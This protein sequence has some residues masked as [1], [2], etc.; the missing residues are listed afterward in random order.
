MSNNVSSVYWMKGSLNL[1]IILK[2]QFGYI[3][4]WY[5]FERLTSNQWKLPLFFCVLTFNNSLEKKICLSREIFFSQKIIY[6]E[7]HHTTW[8]HSNLH[9]FMLSLSLSLTH[10]NTC[11]HAS[12]HTLSYKWIFNIVWAWFIYS[13]IHTPFFA[14]NP[15]ASVW[16]W[17]FILVIFYGHEGKQS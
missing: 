8:R 14:L 1:F 3:R 12:T 13:C 9:N 7:V 10:T 16:V 2:F 6:L 17:T 4:K 11:T 15:F 5:D